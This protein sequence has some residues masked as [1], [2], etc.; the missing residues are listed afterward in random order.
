MTGITIYTADYEPRQI[1]PSGDTGSHDERLIEQIVRIGDKPLALF[2]EF[3]APGGRVVWSFKG[4]R[5]APTNRTEYFIAAFATTETGIFQDFAAALTALPAD[6]WFIPYTED[7]RWNLGFDLWRLPQ[8]SDELDSETCEQLCATLR[9]RY[10]SESSS[11]P[12]V[13]GMTSY[14]SALTVLRVIQAADVQCRVAVGIADNPS[15]IEGL[16]LLLVPNAEAE[17]TAYSDSAKAV[18][19]VPALDTSSTESPTTPA[20][21]D[22]FGG[23]PNPRNV[24]KP[25]LILGTALLVYAAGYQTLMRGGANLLMILWGSLVGI[26][27]GLGVIGGLRLRQTRP[28]FGFGILGSIGLLGSGA[29]I[30]AMAHALGVFQ[31]GGFATITAGIHM[32]ALL[33]V[34]A[35]MAYNYW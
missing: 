4:K 15:R 23:V 28:W 26:N 12:L 17:F 34:S 35:F 2:V 33:V 30:T 24:I 13:L 22:E 16:D 9:E 32:S 31:A 25:A 21:D 10:V 14:Q 27:V 20:T 7:S 3:D 1:Y 5:G 18:I 29:G 19:D 8:L 6:S 11:Q